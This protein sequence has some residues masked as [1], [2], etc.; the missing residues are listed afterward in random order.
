MTID[1]CDL[2]PD[3]LFGDVIHSYTRA[4]AMYDGYLVDVTEEA[5]EAEFNCSVALTR[6]VWEGCVAWIDEDS[7]RQT[8]QDQNGRL[9]D[10][11]CM[12]YFAIRS[13]KE[14]G[15]KLLY[16]LRRFP[17]GGRGRMARQTTLKLISG[18]GD[19]SELL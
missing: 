10:V 1:E 18:Q 19:N 7:K 8:Y 16:Q 11:L 13:S 2:K 5:Q 9:W 15:D 17:C 3:F 12:A 14:Y 4:E 6:A